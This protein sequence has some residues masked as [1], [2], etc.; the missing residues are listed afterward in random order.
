MHPN[1][2]AA[3]SST[4]AALPFRQLPAFE[5][6]S[7]PDI[8]LSSEL[9][10]AAYNVAG[11]NLHV[12]IF[13]HSVRVFAYA[14]RLAAH[15][16]PNTIIPERIHLLFTACVLHDIGASSAH[17]GHQRFEVEGADAAANFLTSYHV[18]TNDVREV[19]MAIALHTS[20]H[21]AER[22]S[23]LSKYVRAAV[24]IDFGKSMV[25]SVFRDNLEKQWPRLEVEKVLGDT[26]VEQA[27]RQPQKA[28]SASWP[29]ILYRS[30][31]E[32]PHWSGIN[33][34]F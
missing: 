9:C 13:N 18:D 1:L 34:A 16:S 15:E 6:A 10:K 26:I 27:V 2:A 19:W 17:D 5:A 7:L 8:V 21:V 25:E 20:P 30:Y 3:S 4:D 14:L 12:A 22:I 11:R 28:P 31:L 23:P 24:L 33:R 32:D 29:G